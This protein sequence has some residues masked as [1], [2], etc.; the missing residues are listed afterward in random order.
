MP[1]PE[2]LVRRRLL[3]LLEESSDHKATLISAPAG[4]G[5]TT[6]LAQWGQ[7]DEADLSFAWVSL[8]EQD[9]DP[10]RLWRHIVEALRQAVPEEDFGADVLVGMSAAGQKLVPRTAATKLSAK[11]RRRPL[12]SLADHR[13]GTFSPDFSLG[14]ILVSVYRPNPRSERLLVPLFRGFL[15]PTF[16]EAEWDSR[17]V[18]TGDL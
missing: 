16:G 13:N 2:Q 6:L 3:T 15:S 11:L 12:C 10:V 1:R 14:P 9:N 7:A 5:K 17:E 18:V 8:D 4:Y